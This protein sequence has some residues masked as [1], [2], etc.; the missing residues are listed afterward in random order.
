M[1]E[2]VAMTEHVMLCCGSTEE[3]KGKKINKVEEVT[4]YRRE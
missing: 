2:D 3:K 4:T 1:K